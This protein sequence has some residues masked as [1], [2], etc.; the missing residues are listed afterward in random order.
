MINKE[1][2]LF[3]EVYVV[4]VTHPSHLRAGGELSGQPAQAGTCTK[5]V[6]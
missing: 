2:I 6:S 4:M 1:N 5:R 3:P